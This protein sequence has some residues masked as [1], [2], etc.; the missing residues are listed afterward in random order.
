MLTPLF[1]C[2]SCGALSRQV[3]EEEIRSHYDVASY[4][5]PQY[6]DR[7]SRQRINFFR[8]LVS[9]VT[10]HSG[11]PPR[12]CLDFG[13]SYGHFLL[14]LQEM[15]W[16]TCGIERSERARNICQNHNL[17]VHGGLDELKGSEQFDL[18]SLIDSLYCVSD[19]KILLSKLR[20]RLTDDGLLLIRIANRNWI[21]H[22]LKSVGRREHFDRWLGDA[23]V[24]YSKSTLNALLRS[25]GY[26]IVSTHY[27][28]PG[29]ENLG[30]R[31]KIFYW[32]STVITCASLGSIVIS[33]GII[34]L[35]A[36]EAQQCPIRRTAA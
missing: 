17:R 25:S 29:K 7:F 16:D 31:R 19:P 15:H 10:R 21:V 33:P 13:C 5:D 11:R 30:W 14:V 6:E 22:L 23:I 9:L 2:G 3:S 12:N 27:W 28:E 8:S 35:A 1:L 36:K 24:C 18:I 32:V 20:E 26:R 4:T 34:V